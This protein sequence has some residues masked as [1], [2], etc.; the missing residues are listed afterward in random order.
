MTNNPVL[1]AGPW[2]NNSHMIAD[3]ARLGY[4]KKEWKTLDPTFGKG[5]FWN[6]WRPD[7][8]VTHDL[9][10]DGVDF[11]NLPY[12]D[13][14]FDAVAFDSP[15]VSVGG[16]VTSGI[17]DMLDAYGMDDAP[18]SPAEVQ[19]LLNTGL[20]EMHRVVKPKGFVLC[21]NQDYISSGQLFPGTHYTLCHALQLGFKYV[22][23]L[24]LVG[25][26]RPQPPG[27]RQVHARRNL[28]TLFVFQKKA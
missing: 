25:S 28:S 4:L 1:A 9:K 15:Y 26:I 18:S 23:R 27:R 21:K 14:T 7:D 11:R 16:R 2:A 20:V 24:E 22:D 5:N 12:P 17:P 10:I 3:V 8:L 6:S 19:A 13:D